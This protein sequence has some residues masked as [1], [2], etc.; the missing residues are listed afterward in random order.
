MNSQE[1]MIPLGALEPIRVIWDKEEKMFKYDSRHDW[2]YNSWQL[3][4]E[5]DQ[6]SYKEVLDRKLKAS[7]LVYAFVNK[8]NSNLGEII[9]FINCQAISNEEAPELF[10]WQL[11]QLLC[12]KCRENRQFLDV[13]LEKLG[14]EYRY[15]DMKKETVVI[16]DIQRILNSTNPFDQKQNNN[17]FTDNNI[18]STNFKDPNTVYKVNINST[19]KGKIIFI[20]ND[21]KSKGFN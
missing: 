12:S 4:D 13:V 18:V 19:K 15:G 3:G 10:M 2:I 20:T 1:N 5:D 16:G 17:P 8:K 9:N 7:E 11:Q 14:L 6:K 21:N